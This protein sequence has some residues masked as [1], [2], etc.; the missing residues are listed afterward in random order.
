MKEISLILKEID[1]GEQDIVIYNITEEQIPIL[2]S[3]LN[4]NTSIKSLTVYSNTACELVVN[5]LASVLQTTQTTEFNPRTVL[6][7]ENIHV[8]ATALPMSKITH[9]YWHKQRTF[10]SNSRVFYPYQN[11]LPSTMW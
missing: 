3:K 7:N 10:K 1:N 8:L 11:H 4:G 6:T 2:I 9:L 5:A